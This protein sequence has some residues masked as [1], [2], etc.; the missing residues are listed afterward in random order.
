[1]QTNTDLDAAEGRMTHPR[2]NDDAGRARSVKDDR[3]DR[4]VG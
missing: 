4:K 2:A 1:M 3:D